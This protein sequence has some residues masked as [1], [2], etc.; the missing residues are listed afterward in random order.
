LLVATVVIVLVA[1]SFA[2]SRFILREERIVA[3]GK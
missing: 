2:I 1:L 3:S